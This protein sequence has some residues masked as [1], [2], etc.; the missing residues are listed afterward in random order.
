MTPNDLSEPSDELS[1][2]GVI[3]L[4]LRDVLETSHLSVGTRKDVG[5]EVEIE[6]VCFV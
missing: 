2:G 1:Y 4:L 3:L 6:R 5:L